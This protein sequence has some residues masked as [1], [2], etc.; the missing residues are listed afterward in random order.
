MSPSGNAM[1][2][3]TMTISPLH[4]MTVMFLPIS[5]KPPKKEIL[6]G[7]F[8]TGST[9]RDLG[10]ELPLKFPLVPCLFLFLE[11]KLCFSL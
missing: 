2:Q 10:L 7:G 9:A 1:P 8:F 3:S 11:Y 6:T 5:F 4:S